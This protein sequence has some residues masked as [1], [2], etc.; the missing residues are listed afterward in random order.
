MQA[1]VRPHDDVQ[2]LEAA[3]MAARKAARQS[4]QAG[5]RWPPCRLRHVPLVS[6]RFRKACRDPSMW[7]E[8]S[9][10][11]AD[12]STEARWRS[13]L[14]WLAVHAPGLQTLAFGSSTCT[15]VRSTLE[16][17]NAPYMARL[18]TSITATSRE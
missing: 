17:G 1:S 13:F 5:M 10:P 12:L 2:R 7:S 18:S 3:A 15:A 8:L 14:R 16:E 9:V 4:P 11:Y 6:R